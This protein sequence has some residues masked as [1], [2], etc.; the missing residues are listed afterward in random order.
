MNSRHESVAAQQTPLASPFDHPECGYLAMLRGMHTFRQPSLYAREQADSAADQALLAE[1]AEQLGSGLPEGRWDL[2]GL[3]TASRR[4]VGE[5]LGRG[6]I[7]IRV[8]AP[9]EK[10]EVDESVFA[11]LWTI[12]R[13]QAGR[14]VENYLES[15]PLPRAVHEW[16]GRLTHGAGPALPAEFPAGIMNAPAV[17][18]EIA[19]KSQNYRPGRDSVVNLSLLPMTPEDVRLVADVLGLAGLSLVSKGYGDCRIR[20]TRVPH[21]WWVQYFNASG[22]LILNTL[23]ITAMPTVALAAAEDLTD[24]AAR[25]A[26]T[27]AV[28]ER[29]P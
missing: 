11:G 8:A 27:L 2:R 17:L 19:A 14:L 29:S 18:A 28:L 1:I 21:V 23:E 25:L 15:G 10:L 26:E 22:Q 24:S 12:R 16:A 9:P 4:F 7:G 6:E 3:D 13:Y 5:V 20:L